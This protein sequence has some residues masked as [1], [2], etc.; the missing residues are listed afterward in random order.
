MCDYV[1]RYDCV[2]EMYEHVCCVHGLCEH[3]DMW[4][5]AHKSVQHLGILGM[6]SHLPGSLVLS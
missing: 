5:H 3:V 6:T 1:S 2:D 4:V